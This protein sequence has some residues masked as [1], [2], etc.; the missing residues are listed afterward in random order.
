MWSPSPNR[1]GPMTAGPRGRLRHLGDRAFDA[2]AERL[3]PRIADRLT[4]P[5]DAVALGDG[6]FDHAPSSCPIVLDYPVTPRPREVSGPPP[7]R[8]LTAQ[9]AAGHQRYLLWT[10]WPPSTT[11]SRPSTSRPATTPG[12]PTGTTVGCRRSMPR[13]STAWW[14]RAG[15]RRT[16]RSARA[17]RRSSCGGRSATMDSP[18][19][20]SRST[21]NPG[22]RSTACATRWTSPIRTPTCRCSGVSRP[23]TRCSSTTHTAACRTAM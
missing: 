8:R 16:S 15:R 19:G 7:H 23:A 10:R 5:T 20:S 13:C 4:G 22:P 3:A 18:P 2:M 9:L 6:A 21:R 14:P 12:S 11:T 17:T 1:V